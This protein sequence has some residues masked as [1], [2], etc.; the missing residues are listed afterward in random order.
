M[1]VL[2]PSDLDREDRNGLAA[3]LFHAQ[4]KGKQ[5]F[6]GNQLGVADEESPAPKWRAGGAGLPTKRPSMLF[7]NRDNSAIEKR[8]ET[9]DHAHIVGAPH[10]AAAGFNGWWKSPAPASDF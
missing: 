5:G 4:D 8:S 3:L 1:S 7:S 9:L 2:S 10:V 6:A